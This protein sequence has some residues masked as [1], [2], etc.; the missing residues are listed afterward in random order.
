MTDRHVRV[1]VGFDSTA[2]DAVVRW[3]DISADLSSVQVT[4]GRSKELDA[5][6][7]G[8]AT[9]RL[10][11]ADG[12]YTPG[13]ATSPYAGKMKPRKPVRVYT[14]VDNNV[15][16]FECVNSN[17]A[18]LDSPRFTP[19]GEYADRGPKVRRSFDREIEREVFEFE[20]PEPGVPATTQYV[21]GLPGD[22]DAIAVRAG[23]IVH[24]TARFSNGTPGD[25]FG[26]RF[27]FHDDTSTGFLDVTAFGP[28]YVAGEVGWSTAGTSL[29]AEAD[30]YVRLHL[31]QVSSGDERSYLRLADVKVTVN[32]D[33]PELVTHPASG[34][35]PLIRGYVDTWATE[36]DGDLAYAEIQAVDA[37]AVV[38]RPIR[39]YYRHQL[40]TWHDKLQAAGST[41][42]LHYWPCVTGTDDASAE[43]EIGSLSLTRAATPEPPAVGG[44][45]DTKTMEYADGMASGGF[46]VDDE[47]PTRGAVL[48][49]NHHGNPLLPLDATRTD[50]QWFVGFWYRGQLP[51]TGRHC[52]FVAARANGARLA[53]LWLNP[54]GSITAEWA[55]NGT[56]PD[57]TLTETSTVQ[58]DVPTFIGLWI[59]AKDLSPRAETTIGVVK[60]T[61]VRT[62]SAP[63]FNP[64][65]QPAFTQFGGRLYGT[66]STEF[67]RGTI[68]HVVWATGLYAYRFFQDVPDYAADVPADEVARLDDQL[69]A[70]GWTGTRQLDAPL[71]ILLAPRWNNG[72]DA[73]GLLGHTA[74][75]AGGEFFIGPAGEA[76]YHNRHRRIGV[77]PRWHIGEWATGLRFELD[78]SRV[79]NVVRAERSTGL[80]RE[81]S[82]PASIAEHGTKRLPVRRDVQDPDEVH[83]AAGWLLHRYRESAPRCEVLT[84]D[85]SALNGPADGQLLALAHGAAVSDRI[86]LY[87]LPPSAPAPELAFYVEGI[88]TSIEVDGPHLRAKTVLQVSDA[89]RSDGWILEYGNTGVLDADTC[90]AVY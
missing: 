28:G 10:D 32:T 13:R 5:I 29:L 43:P 54:N 44:F 82:D 20:P 62:T 69:N 60:G 12:V 59:N 51:V 23:D 46:T 6:E 86:R 19:Y 64:L 66:T 24:V 18:D 52:L 41:G 50:N 57:L 34:M 45:S 22:S 15:L 49:L 17:V 70:A 90:V 8:Q 74:N 21:F 14:V 79:Y 36:Y 88:R 63:A 84:I 25:V 48:R 67:V 71:S 53:G 81:V 27:A 7:A 73:N 78:S 55:G 80:F 56:G 11:N 77:S 42:G 31:I 16:H 76:V 58:P 2:T 1:E 4:R 3:T 72:D 85:A 38:S 75:D 33:F 47:D 35:Y 87:D 40:H 9:I 61:F 37:L 68:N 26:I 39:S 65:P 30:G 83:Q 89:A